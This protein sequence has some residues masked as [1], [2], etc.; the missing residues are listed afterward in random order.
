MISY[1]YYSGGGTENACI[2]TEG[3]YILAGSAQHEN[4]D[5]NLIYIAKLDEH[6]DTLWTRQYFKDTTWVIARGICNTS[7]GGFMLVGET[8]LTN[9]SIWGSHYTYA[10][11]LKLDANGNYQWFKSFGTDTE[12]DNF[13]KVV[14]TTDG[15]YL[16]GGATMSW[17]ENLNWVDKGDWYIVKTDSEGNEEWSRRYGHA[18]YDDDR[19]T[20]ILKTRDTSYYITGSWTYGRNSTGST[21]YK[22]AYI[23]KLDKDFNEVYQLKYDDQAYLQSHPMPAIESS[24]SNIVIL[25]FKRI[26]HT[27]KPRTTIHKIT[28]DGD[29]LWQRQY[30]ADSDTMTTNS[31]AYSIKECSDKGFVFGG[32]A[33]AGS[34]SPSQQ[35]WLVKTDSLG[36]DGTG[37]FADDCTGV[38]I[39][40]YASNPEFYLY[41]NPTKSTVFVRSRK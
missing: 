7:D 30:V 3:G 36:C 4:L 41:P 5:T 6:F 35:M 32:Y 23:V 28:P 26:D 1:S 18:Y 40:E 33:S 25:G 8:K 20:E 27:Y 11:M 37:D 34:L 10:L 12:N 31:I 16:V 39:K 29:I 19:V 21:K 22:E 24:D 9:D 17:Q 2:K 38:V 15:G 14:Q 13:Y